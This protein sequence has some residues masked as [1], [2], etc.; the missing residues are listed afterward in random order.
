MKKFF[1]WLFVKTIVPELKIQFV[2]DGSS[3]DWTEDKIY[4]Q[5]NEPDCGFMRHLKQ[6]HHFK[7]ANCIHLTIWT[8]LHEIGHYFTL[9]DCEEDLE[10]KA[11]C[12]IINKDDAEHMEMLQDMY[13]NMESE[14]EATEWAINYV[15]NH[16]KKCKI[17]S[18]LVK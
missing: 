8:L 11:I 2:K 17:F 9:D 15:I 6:V 13:F 5:F 12:S 3:F 16:Y 7:K 1:C 14:W 10:T 18:K 4:F